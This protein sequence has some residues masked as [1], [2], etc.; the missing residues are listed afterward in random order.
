VAVTA[1]RTEVELPVT[2]RVR[3]V[4]FNRDETVPVQIED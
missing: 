1:A 2:G 4:Q 3:R